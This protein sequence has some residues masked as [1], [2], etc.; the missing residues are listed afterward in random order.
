MSRKL[1]DEAIGKNRAEHPEWFPLH[2]FVVEMRTEPDISVPASFASAAQAFWHR[3]VDKHDVRRKGRDMHYSW[4]SAIV[5][6]GSPVNVGVFI[7]T[8]MLLDHDNKT[9]VYA[10]VHKGGREQDL[11]YQKYLPLQ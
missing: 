6:F 9:F 1:T 5:T 8:N 3:F 10:H 11:A 2:K 7:S 4:F